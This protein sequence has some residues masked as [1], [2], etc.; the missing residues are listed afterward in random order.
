MNKNIRLL[1]E[2][3]IDISNY[4]K[5]IILDFEDVPANQSGSY[6]ADNE[7][8]VDDYTYQYIVDN[9]KLVLLTEDN[10]GKYVGKKIKLRS[11]MYCASQKICRHCIGEIPKMLNIEAI[12]LTTGRIANTILAKKM[13]LFHNAKVKFDE[14]DINDLLV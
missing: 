8:E 7:Y 3:D 14:I 2:N 4:E 9:G 12:G 1:L 13:K 5:E 10:A 6:V 11:P